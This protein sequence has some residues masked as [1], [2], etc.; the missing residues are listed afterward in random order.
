[1]NNLVI[2]GRVYNEEHKFLKQWLEK[3]S[4]LT[5]KLVI[6]DDGS[7]DNTVSICSKYTSNIHHTKN[8]FLINESKVNFLLWDYCT[9]VADNNDFILIIGNDELMTESSLE[10]FEEQ[11]YNCNKLD[12][13]AISWAKYDMWSN[14]QYRED[15][16]LWNAHNMLWTWCV[17]YKKHRKYY[18]DNNKLHSTFIPLNS[19]YANYATKLQIQ[20]MAYSTPE[21]RIQHRKFYEE[22]DKNGEWDSIEKYNSILD[23]N[24]TLIDFKDNFEDTNE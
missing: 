14:T 7:T 20:H 21:L 3:Y 23:E 10:H 11:I 17:K 6:L 1:M 24:P 9:K 15:P 16:P 19:F 2:G 4:K 12:G 5:D 18:W 8:L 13:D 22:I